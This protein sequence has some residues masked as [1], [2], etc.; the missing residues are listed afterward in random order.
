[1]GQFVNLSTACSGEKT[2]KAENALFSASVV[3]VAGAGL[4]PTTFGL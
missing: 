1:M 3:S 4:E 2:K